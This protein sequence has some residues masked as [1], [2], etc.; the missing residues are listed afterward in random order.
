[1]LNNTRKRFTT[2]TRLRNDPLMNPF[3]LASPM[4]NM[5]DESL[6]ARMSTAAMATFTAGPAIA[7]QSSCLGSSGMRSSARRRRWAGV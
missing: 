5:D 3:T 7:T 2:M 4:E 6:V 1:M